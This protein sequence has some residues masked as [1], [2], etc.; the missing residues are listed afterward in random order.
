MPRSL[1]LDLGGDDLGRADLPEEFGV[2][3]AALAEDASAAPNPDAGQR[4]GRRDRV[5]L[6]A[7]LPARNRRQLDRDRVLLEMIEDDSPLVLEQDGQHTVPDVVGEESAED[8]RPCFLR[9]RQGSEQ[10]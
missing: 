5:P 4:F 2:L 1:V 3:W 10:H 6:P 9:G 7:E 8:G